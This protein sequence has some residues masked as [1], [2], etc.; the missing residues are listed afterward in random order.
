M[1]PPHSVIW[2]FCITRADTMSKKNPMTIAPMS[3]H[4]RGPMRP[5][6]RIPPSPSS[7]LFRALESCIV[8]R[9]SNPGGY[10]QGQ[11]WC[12]PVSPCLPITLE[13]KD[14]ADDGQNRRRT[15]CPR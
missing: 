7:L 4:Q 12:G 6:G 1:S 10:D 3:C 15:M 2:H 8:E 13:G 5:S 9:S 11:L 14:Q